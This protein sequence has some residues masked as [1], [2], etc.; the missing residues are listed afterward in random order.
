LLLTSPALIHVRVINLQDPHSMATVPSAIVE[1]SA[2]HAPTHGGVRAETRP[3]R[4][5][6]SQRSTS[7]YKR[8]R[9]AVRGV[10]IIAVLWLAGLV[11]FRLASRIGRSGG[12]VAYCVLHR[13]RRRALEHL[14]IAFPEKAA[15]ERH[16]IARRSFQHLG[17]CAA[18]CAHSHRL[19]D[20][21]ASLVEFPISAQRL[22]AEALAEGKGAIMVSGHIGNWELLPQRLVLAGYP[23]CV[24]AREMNTPLL[25]AAVDLFRGRAGVRTIWRGIPSAMREMLRVFRDNGVLG[26]LIDQD[27]K[28]R[29]TFVPFFGVPAATP[30]AAG[31]L[32]VRT[33]APL[34]AAFI[35][36]IDRYRHIISVER[37]HI[38]MT[39]DSEADSLALTAAAT[40]AIERAIRQNPEQWVWMHRRWKTRP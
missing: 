28:V 36:R 27:T 37:I 19:G 14:R 34:L 22:V 39:G 18:E 20:E 23:P 11:P 10:L 29:S 5:P 4:L 1:S 40:A 2:V 31:D 12:L 7:W 6:R 25:N 30:R 13:D 15:R 8:S 33:G 35:R 26:L 21:L 32:S 9:R 17:Q 38:Q 24:V 16:L 3:Q